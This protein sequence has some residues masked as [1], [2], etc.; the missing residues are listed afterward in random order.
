[1]GQSLG[2]IPLK[3]EL[4]L[5]P[6]LLRGGFLLFLIWLTLQLVTYIDI[7]IVQGF[8]GTDTVGLYSRT[9]WLVF[10]VATFFYPRA[11]FPTLVEYRMDRFRFIEFF[12]LSAVQLLGCQ[13]I[14]SYFLFFNASRVIS[15]LFGDDWLGAVPILKML[16]FVPFLGQ[17][18]ILGGEVLKAQHRDKLWLL[19]MALNLASLVGVGFALTRQWGAVGM[20]GANY[21]L[22]G[23]LIIMWQI[24][25][26]LGIRFKTLI[27]DLAFLYAAPL[28]L[29]ASAAWMFVDGS[30]GRLIGSLIAAVFSVGLFVVRYHK[31][32]SKFFKSGNGSGHRSYPVAKG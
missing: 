19:A 9:Y 1:M 27:G 10:L 26:T 12:R 16:S 17:F 14:G 32:F 6:D 4:K 30:W 20:A 18:A 2:K 25:K 15:V 8:R 21:F 7:F 13:V 28:P 11:F 24:K 23:D 5:L 22:V 3:V 29:F 31:D